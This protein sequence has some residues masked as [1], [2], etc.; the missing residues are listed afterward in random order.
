MTSI[1]WNDSTQYHR[2][3]IPDQ[4]LFAIEFP[5]YIRNVD[6]AIEALGGMERIAEV[7]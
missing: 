4:E 5:G 2:G 7:S 1:P 6:K 3:T